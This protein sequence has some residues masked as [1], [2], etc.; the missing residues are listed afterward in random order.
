M[1]PAIRNGVILAALSIAVILALAGRSHDRGA[2][3][4]GASEAALASAHTPGTGG[5]PRLVDV[6]ADQCIPCKAMA[7]I[8]ASLRVDYAGRFE[9][10][11]VDVWKDP[12]AGRPYRVYMIPTQ[13]F[14]DGAGRE[15]HRHQG[16]ISR[17]DILATWRRLGYDFEAPQA[18]P[19]G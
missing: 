15:L 13:I 10:V 5:L 19:R 14:F 9:V 17:E 16:F 7:P 11:F 8:L 3:P 6:G 4:T 2:S 18:P 12:A 1:R